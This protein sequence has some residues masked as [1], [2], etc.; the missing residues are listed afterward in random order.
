MT[1]LVR[2]QF[3]AG[4]PAVT[5]EWADDSTARRTWRDW[6]GL[7]GSDERVVIRLAEETGGSE[8]VLL[9]WERG[10]AVEGSDGG[11]RSGS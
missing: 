7:Y 8:R 2:L 6:I 9:T 1:Y 10:R 4:G 3:V 11:H 5:G